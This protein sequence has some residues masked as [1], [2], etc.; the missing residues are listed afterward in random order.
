MA[1]SAAWGEDLMR[2]YWQKI[3]W[4]WSCSA[5]CLQISRKEK[6]VVKLQEVI[7]KRN[8]ILSWDAKIGFSQSRLST[9][10]KFVTYLPA[11]IVVPSTGSSPTVKGGWI[12]YI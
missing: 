11:V 3:A 10:E 5:M 1:F 12:L 6:L 7:D 4:S 2:D 9:C 8:Y